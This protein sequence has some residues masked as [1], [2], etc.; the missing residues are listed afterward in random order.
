MVKRSNNLAEDV[1]TAEMGREET[2]D[3]DNL[4]QR[5][6]EEKSKQQS[7]NSKLKQ[8]SDNDPAVLQEMA[9]EAKQAVDAANRWTDNIFSLQSWIKKKFPSVDQVQLILRFQYFNI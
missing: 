5:L 9:Q 1:S 4:L 3:R 8:F 7:F 2:S 6:S